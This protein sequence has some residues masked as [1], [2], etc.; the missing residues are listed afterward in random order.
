MEMPMNKKRIMKTTLVLAIAFALF[1]AG[2]LTGKNNFSQPS[3]IIHLVTVKWKPDST[4]EQQQQALDGIKTMAAEIPGIKNVWIKSVRV[5]PRE[6]NS[7][8][9]MEF[10]NKA[11]A[12]A[13]V[14]HPAHTAWGK[15][16]EPIREE[17]RSQQVTN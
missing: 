4:P 2:I 11:A 3:T 6:F 7:V 12:D 14:D 15:I 5:Q 9:A 13:Y 1:G 17:S 16:Y 10:E 8:F